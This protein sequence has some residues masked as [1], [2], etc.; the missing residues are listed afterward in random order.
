MCGICGVVDLRGGRIPVSQGVLDRMTDSMIHR[1]PNDRGTLLEPGIA[2]GARRLSIID[3]ADGHQPFANEDGRIWSV[4]NGELYNHDELRA[5][6]RRDG[7]RF[8]T[9]CDTE[10][11]PHLYERDGVRFPELVDGKFAIATWDRG[12]RRAVLA[13]DRL[14]IKP[15]YYA[16]AADR[17]VFGSE[18]KAVLASGLVEADLDYDAIDAYLTFGFFPGPGTPLRAVRKLMPG[19]R[20]IVHDGQIRVEAYWNYPEPVV[21]SPRLSEAE[22]AEG[23]LE[24]LDRAVQRRLM[25]DV[26]V[27]AML[28]GGLDS[29][30]IVALMAQHSP[31]PVET[32][33]IGF[34]EAGRDMELEDARM[35]AQRF[36]TVHHEVELSFDDEVVSLPDLLWH[37]D[38]PMVD[39]SSIGLYALSKLA[40]QHVTVALS[41]QGA[42]EL[43]GGYKKH[44]AAALIDYWSRLPRPLRT[45]ALAVGRRSRMSGAR[46]FA[47]LEAADNVGRQL[48]MSGRVDADLRGRLYRGQLAGMRGDAAARAVAERLP[49]HEVGV[50]ASTLHVDGTLA[51]VDDMLHYFD[52][53]SMAH[54]LEVR[55]PFLD[56]ELV[57]YCAGIPPALKVRGLTTKY[58]LKRAARD[59]LPA[60]IVHKRKLGFFR[61]AAA[62]WLAN[63][64]EGAG[65][66]YLTA[67][68]PIYGEFL[69]RD[70]VVGLVHDYTAGDRRHVFLLTSL[71]MLEV[72]LQTYVARARDVADVAA[73]RAV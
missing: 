73:A 67:R 2:L 34:T 62:G 60:E 15:L 40:A 71:M 63:Q 5:E 47:T 65:G 50:L 7:H 9:R 18:L 27:G 22:F 37:L 64:I 11:L 20:L 70:A 29:S 42:D 19:S 23:L 32:F 69:D 56:H 68:E 26:P 10:I 12:Q 24:N 57:E 33:A 45:A 44:R 43:L 6:L 51:L 39:I 59:I 28:S 48:A 55:V 8:A 46:A 36:G 72:W 1:G 13:R 17:L 66:D 35:I 4:Q 52:R 14:G 58:L 3:V 61:P 54:S 30:L 25:S 38:E 16:V 21:T 53:V 41:G 31:T 49:S